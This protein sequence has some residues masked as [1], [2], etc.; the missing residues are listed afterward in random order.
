MGMAIIPIVVTY[1]AIPLMRIHICIYKLY[2]NKCIGEWI[3]GVA[4][5]I[6]KYNIGLTLERERYQVL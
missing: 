5:L 4:V 3:L 6:E 1:K 2:T